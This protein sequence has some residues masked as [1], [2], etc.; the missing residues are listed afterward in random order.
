MRRRDNYISSLSKKILS[1][2]LL[3]VPGMAF[4]QLDSI[5]HLT[6]YNIFT[7]PITDKSVNYLG[8]IFGT[9][10]N[11][12]HGTSGQLL[13]QLFEVF[14][15]AMVIIAACILIYT[16]IVSVVNTA[17]EGEFLGKNTKSA[18]IVLRAV[19]GIG[20]LVP[21]YTGYSLIQVF[22][23]WVVVQGIGLADKAW[24]QAI[25]YLTE[26]GGVVYAEPAESLKKGGMTN[27]FSINR[28]ILDSEVCMYKLQDLAEKDKAAAA[29]KLKDD[30]SNPT[31]AALAGKSISTYKPVWDD[32]TQTVSFG[33]PS[34]NPETS[35]ACGQYSWAK[36]ADQPDYFTQYKRIG[37]QQ[38]VM[39]M[40]A[41]AKTV[42]IY[43]EQ[44]LNKSQIEILK[45]RVLSG[46]LGA[47]ADYENVLAPA[48][49]RLSAEGQGEWKDNLKEAKAKGWIL[50]GSYYWDLAKVNNKLSE[51]LGAYQ[52]TTNWGV[53]QDT[54]NK[55]GVNGQAVMDTLAFMKK[56]VLLDDAQQVL[57]ILEDQA[58]GTFNPS[59]S[60]AL[61]QLMT[62]LTSKD[63]KAREAAIA[64]LE[65][66]T[67]TYKKDN[68][69]NTV[70]S[71]SSITG[72][73]TALGITGA[74]SIAGA[75]ASPGVG[76]VLTSLWA[77]LTALVG[78]WHGVM[79]SPGDP[80][81]MVQKLGQGMIGISMAM[82]ILGSALLG[83]TTAALSIGGSATGIAYGIQNGLKMFVPIV[84]GFI[85]VL[86]VNGMV[87]STYIPLIPFMIFSFAAIGWLIAVLE[88]V[89]AGPLIA[90]AITHPEGHDLMGQ[91]NQTVQMLM[92]VF[93][94]PVV[95]IIG[96][97]A[98][99]ILARVSLR[100]INAG[101]SH[102]VDASNITWSGFNI[103]GIA[104]VMVI[105]TMI[106]ISIINLVFNAGVVKLWETIWMWVGF[107]QPQHSTEQAMQE[108]KGGL[109]S[110]AQHMG[111]TTGQ[112]PKAG[113][114]VRAAQIQTA[115][116]NYNRSHG[117]GVRDAG[118]EFDN[119][120]HAQRPAE[121]PV[122]NANASSQNP[123]SGV[124][125]QGPVP[126]P[127][128]DDS[129]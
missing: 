37:L 61:T 71:S 57:Q 85:G 94:R 63:P 98:A 36:S 95:M 120:G 38:T 90:A 41:G 7:P 14:N 117:G 59:T 62:D 16:I 124:G 68:D 32:K 26:E 50:A 111:D 9:V 106:V 91:A 108:V 54:L 82:W 10:G 34:S 58:G 100:F 123:Q 113:A 101:F 3:L 78:T 6:G 96:F 70:L 2:L 125:G 121:A 67:N 44:N 12:I 13:A 20:I 79:N 51:G 88:A 99:I 65:Q 92:G 87:L 60:G 116:D 80:I 122:V 74:A 46:T 89:V 30:P 129:D 69:T 83:L 28:S 64:Q 15:Y 114:E 23:M 17:H 76:I 11:V 1:F 105:Y 8:Q 18:W 97:L 93:L 33:F 56:N 84:I 22:I 66:I 45:N 49:R 72:M 39:D 86:F 81:V 115:L 119:T 102:M 25:T 109:Q 75:M 21:K 107:H 52:A 112:L 24:D 31:L 27:T 4:A 42:A 127:G 55:D 73:Y 126:V 128:A 29:A 19:L 43:S 77:S 35:S 47:T 48:L 104:G 118:I 103:F 110:G 5:T 53:N 40:E